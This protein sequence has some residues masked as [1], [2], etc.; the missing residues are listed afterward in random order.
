VITSDAIETKDAVACHAVLR[1]EGA[2]RV[3]ADA[4]LRIRP[5]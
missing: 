3:V 2:G 4:H 5:L 1:D